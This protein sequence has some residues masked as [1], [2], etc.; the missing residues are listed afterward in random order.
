VWA[1]DT[2]A[3]CSDLVKSRL[4]YNVRDYK[5]PDEMLCDNRNWKSGNYDMTNASIK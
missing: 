3:K 4:G 1:D 2:F 5:D